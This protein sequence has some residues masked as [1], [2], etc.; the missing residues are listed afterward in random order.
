MAHHKWRRPQRSRAGCKMCK[1][2][3]TGFYHKYH[4]M[5]EKH[6]DHKRR[7]FA[8]EEERETMARIWINEHGEEEELLEV[9]FQCIL[10]RT[11]DS[12]YLDLGAKQIWV[13]NQFVGNIDE[14]R[15]VVEIA[16]EFAQEQELV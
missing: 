16:P 6:S 14:L 10:D 7:I 12:M 5:Y 3:K 1:P 11:E 15:G 8:R 9:P 13:P 4:E 2:W